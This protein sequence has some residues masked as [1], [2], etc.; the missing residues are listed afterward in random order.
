MP[1]FYS[2]TYKN[3]EIKLRI[4]QDY[5]PKQGFLSLLVCT[6]KPVSEMQKYRL[7]GMLL[8]LLSL[9]NFIIRLNN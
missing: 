8:D 9:D 4:K 3:L 1:R 6:K 7:Q 2:F 5:A